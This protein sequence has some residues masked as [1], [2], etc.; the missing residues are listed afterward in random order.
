MTLETFVAAM[1]GRYFNS[2]DVIERYTPTVNEL[3]RIKKMVND[4]CAVD[5]LQCTEMFS[6]FKA[7]CPDIGKQ[8]ADEEVFYA[9]KNGCAVEEVPA[10]LIFL[11]R[12]AH[13]A[14]QCA[15]AVPHMLPSGMLD[16]VFTFGY[17]RNGWTMCDVLKKFCDS[18]FSLLDKVGNSTVTGS[19]VD[20]LLSEDFQYAHLPKD[21]VARHNIEAFKVYEGKL[22]DEYSHEVDL[23]D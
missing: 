10:K 22:Y 3:T 18:K 20:F 15:N 5:A 4:F 19:G 21:Y 8:M 1:E 16:K 6:D 17:L 13:K 11:C 12:K 7:I 23:N 2:Y 9:L 14:S